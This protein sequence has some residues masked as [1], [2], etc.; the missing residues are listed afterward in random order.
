MTIRKLGEIKSQGLPRQ[1]TLNL[2]LIYK[3]TKGAT[4]HPSLLA[5]LGH[6]KL[7][8]LKSLIF[9]LTKLLIYFTQKLIQAF[10]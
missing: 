4:S 3:H 7:K 6:P 10:K 8:T 2:L 9:P 1:H 5:S